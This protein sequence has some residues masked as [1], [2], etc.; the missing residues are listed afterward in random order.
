MDYASYLYNTVQFHLAELSG[1]IHAKTFH[2]QFELFQ[3]NPLETASN[4]RLWFI[5]YLFVLAFGKAFL[6]H[7]GQSN[8]A[9]PPGSEYA[10][11]AM[12]LLPD[13]S[14]LHN[15]H[16]LAIEV[17]ALVS[18]YFQSIDQRAVAYQYVRLAS[19]ISLLI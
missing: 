4:N 13:V 9:S 19:T 7:S 17:L 5:Q 14:E 8:T 10:A 16:L 12:A 1:L 6:A 15:A 3:S 2:H 11:C 18:L